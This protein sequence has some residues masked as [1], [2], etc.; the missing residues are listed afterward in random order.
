VAQFWQRI[1]IAL[2]VEVPG[3]RDGGTQ[4]TPFFGILNA[5]LMRTSKAT[6]SCAVRSWVLESHHMN[7]FR[8]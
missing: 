5:P 1:I 4:L 6:R 7:A 3:S 2:I 8:C